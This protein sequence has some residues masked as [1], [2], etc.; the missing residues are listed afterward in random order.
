MLI[1]RYKLLLVIFL[2]TTFSFTQSSSGVI[3]V[4]Y[5]NYYKQLQQYAYIYSGSEYFYDDKKLTDNAFFETPSFEQ[6]ILD[7]D[8]V[9]IPNFPL[10][11][12]I[13]RDELVTINYDKQYKVK[14][15]A[16]KVKSFELRGKKFI[17]VQH[18]AGLKE[19]Y[20]QVLD[21]GKDVLLLSKRIKTITEK[22]LSNKVEYHVSSVNKYWLIHKNHVYGL[23]HQNDL[24]DV[25]QPEKTKLQQY[26]TEQL[27]SVIQLEDRLT[28]LIKYYISLP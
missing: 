6:G 19:G 24:L 27:S 20:Y 13:I 23:E 22:V 1:L 12:D 10:A 15:P 7:F 3:P 8:G 26:Y 11:Y 14:I 18:Y 25:L 21:E 5:N 4:P 17:N 9:V 2:K 16:N 28:A